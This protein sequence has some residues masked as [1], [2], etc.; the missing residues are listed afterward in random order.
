MGQFRE[1]YERDLLIRGY[2]SN[3]VKLYVCC[4][5]NLVKHFMRPPD[6]LTVED[7]NSF[8]LHLT[9]ERKVAWNTFNV[10]VFAIRSYFLGTLKRDWNIKFIPYQKTGRKLPEILNGK[11]LSA[12][13]QSLSNIK[14]LS[15]LMTTYS[16]GLRVSE[17]TH[18]KVSDIDSQRMVIRV[19][20]G[21]GRKDRYVPLSE[22]LLPVLRQYWTTVRSRDWLFP[23]QDPKKPLT[24]ASVEMVFKKA[25]KNAGIKKNVTVHS[26]RHSF[27]THLMEKG[28]DIRTIQQ[29]LG[30]RSLSST[31]IYTHVAENYISTTGSPL[32][33]LEENEKLLPLSKS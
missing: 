9:R 11:E 2:S 21:K 14:H 20:Q 7:I 4:I 3:T 10:Y 29:L 8:Q 30:H 12:M 26:L 24:R 19:D 33:R 23:G 13:F 27:A 22:T 6:K 32:D 17:T 1:K 5:R 31:M 16:A 18:L 28:V 15:I 25:K